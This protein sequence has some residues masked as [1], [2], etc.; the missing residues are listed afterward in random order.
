MSLNL[1]DAPSV[2]KVLKEMSYPTLNTVAILKQLSEPEANLAELIH[3]ISKPNIDISRMTK[4]FATARESGLVKEAL[5]LAQ[6]ESANQAPSINPAV[7]VSDL[8]AEYEKLNAYIKEAEKQL[9]DLHT[10]TP[11]HEVYEKDIFDNGQE[12]HKALGWQRYAGA[13]RL[14]HGYAHDINID[15]FE[16]RPLVDCAADIRLAA[17]EVYGKLRCALVEAANDYVG[18]VRKVN[19]ALSV[20]LGTRMF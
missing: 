12:T 5:A 3:R 11:C 16:W 7:V 6:S 13:W 10:P 18:K 20:L 17:M 14:C 4:R 2:L 19:E 9:A 15:D 1:T 8:L